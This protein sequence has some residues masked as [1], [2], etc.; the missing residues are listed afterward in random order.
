MP[1]FLGKRNHDSSLPDEPCVRG[2]VIH[3][4]DAVCDRS[5]KLRELSGKEKAEIA[6]FVTRCERELL[7]TFLVLRKGGIVHEET[8]TGA[9]GDVLPIELVPMLERP[10]CL[11]GLVRLNRIDGVLDGGVGSS[12]RCLLLFISGRLR[13]SR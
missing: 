6:K 9:G 11:L 13:R 2:G 4:S 8:A 10:R 5:L 1:P 3:D 7:L 12:G